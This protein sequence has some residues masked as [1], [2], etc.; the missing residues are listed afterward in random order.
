[1][2]NMR[3]I[4]VA[5]MTKDILGFRRVSFNPACSG[6][7]RDVPVFRSLFRFRNI[8]VAEPRGFR[9]YQNFLIFPE[10]ATLL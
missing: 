5:Q 10:R 8:P 1:M 9:N 2:R 6:M 3:N 7:F 4:A